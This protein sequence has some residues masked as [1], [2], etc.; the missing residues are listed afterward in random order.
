MKR[1]RFFAVVALLLAFAVAAAIYW[2][3][4]HPA[5]GPMRLERRNFAD[6]PGWSAADPRPALA[7][8]RRSCAL[9]GAKAPTQPIGPYGGAVG[10]WLS[11]CD[12]AR[13]N[14]SGPRAARAFFERWFSPFEVFAGGVGD[15]LFTGYYEPELRGSRMKS[16][17]YAAPVYGLP[18][19]LI[20]VD[21][22]RFP[23][24]LSTQRIAGRL[25]G[26]ALVPYATRAEIDA[27]GLGRAK[28]LF[29]ADDPIAVFFLHIQ[30]SGRVRFA[31][32]ATAR[33][34][35]A[36]QNGWPYTPIGR[37]L[38]S[39]M[40]L[41]RQGMSMQT[42]RA[43]LASHPSDAR[44]IMESD[45]SFVFFRELPIGDPGLGSPGAEGAPLQ[46]GASLAVDAK[47]H[48]LGAP[49]YVATNMPDSKTPLRRLF[50]AQDTGGAIRGP[51][52]A[53]IFF[54]FGPQAEA[55][56]GRMKQPGSIFVLL[57]NPVAQRLARK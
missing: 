21:L 25:D 37:I 44:R 22:G 4:T 53:D 14:P 19:D 47:I 50:V 46:P 8:F 11:A 2:R 36:G 15:G 33:V 43:W 27:H 9:F 24:A 23:S 35:Y 30:G 52:R 42:I 5:P 17:R 40:G 38:I 56:A 54:G 3:L 10:D 48:P 12:A 34:A 28:V 32:G 29:Y 16:G 49:F 18:D 6:L 45:A 51:L 1:P 55:D 13:E 41:S 39:E 57:P 31:D 20:T 7:A 26:S